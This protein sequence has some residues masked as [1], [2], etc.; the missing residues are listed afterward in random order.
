MKHNPLDMLG[1]LTA[2]EFMRDYWQKRPLLV[3]QAFPGLKPPVSTSDLKK[4]SKRDDVQSRL[5]L[6]EQGQWQLE[7]GPLA[8]AWPIDQTARGEQA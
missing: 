2:T 4:L 6:Q 8:R 7:H 3:K 5:I 1:G